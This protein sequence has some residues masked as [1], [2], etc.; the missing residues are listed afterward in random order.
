MSTKP[1]GETEGTSERRAVRRAG[2]SRTGLL[3]QLPTAPQLPVGLHS[4]FP[5]STKE[6]LEGSTSVGQG[7][8]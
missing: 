4:E 6:I 8:E 1:P 2:R 5:R 3:R 7:A